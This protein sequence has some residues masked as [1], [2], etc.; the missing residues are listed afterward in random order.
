MAYK[1]REDKFKEL[2]EFHA[3]IKRRMYS[4]AAELGRR[5]RWSRQ[6]SQQAE[7]MMKL[8]ASAFWNYFLVSQ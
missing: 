4:K 7:V 6:D 2:K 3:T 1:L 8:L 5:I